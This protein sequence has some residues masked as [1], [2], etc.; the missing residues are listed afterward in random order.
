MINYGVTGGQ[1]LVLVP[2]IMAGQKQ[3]N[4]PPNISSVKNQVKHETRT[5]Q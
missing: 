4:I 1:C 2:D 5:P 3:T